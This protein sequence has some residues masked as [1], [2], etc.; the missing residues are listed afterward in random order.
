MRNALLNCTAATVLAAALATSAA[1]E[2]EEASETFVLPN[3]GEIRAFE[4][5]LSPF[6]GEINAFEGQVNPFWGEIRAFWGEINPFWGEIRAFWGEI[7]A[8]DGSL[9]PYWGEIRAFWDEM[10]PEWGTLYAQWGEIRA[11]DDDASDQYQVI[12]RDLETMFEQAEAV[13]GAAVTD[14]SGS[15]F[16]DAFLTTLLAKYDIDLHD[17]SSLGEL[18]DEARS[19]FF[20]DFYDGLMGYSGV[21]RFDHWMGTANWTPALAQSAGLGDGVTVGLL[22]FAYGSELNITT[23]HRHGDRDDFDF[24]HGAAVASLI[25]SPHDGEGLMGVAPDVT[26]NVYNPFD[27][28]L[29]ASWS[30]VA[31]GITKLGQMKSDIINM[32]LGVPGWT[33]HQDWANVLGDSKVAMEAGDAL[34]VIAAGNDGSS[35]QIDVDWS[36]VG[37]AD[38]LLVVG[39]VGPTGEISSFS[40]RPGDACL[41]VNGACDDANRLMNRFLVAPGELVLVSDGEG[42]VT[43]LSG[44]SFAAPLVSG[45]AA[46]VQSRWEWLDAPHTADVLLRSATDLGAPGVDPVYGR[47]MLN[48]EAALSPLDPNALV[49]ASPNGSGSLI[50]ANGQTVSTDSLGNLAMTSGQLRFAAPD[51]HQISAFEVLGDTYRDFVLPLNDVLIDSAASDGATVAGTENYLAERTSE[52][53]QAT[54]GKKK[55][56]K[57][58]F[59]DATEIVTALSAN[60][61]WSLGMTAAPRDPLEQTRDG[62][63]PFQTGLAMTN[64]AAGVEL[65]LGVGEGALALSQQTGFGL[66]SDHRPESGGV[67]PVLG[68]ASG[69]GYVMSGAQLSEATH[70]S[71]GATSTRDEHMYRDPFTGEERPTLTGLS[72]YTATAFLID[73]RHDLSDRVSINAGY[74]LLQEDAGVLG[75]QGST[76]LSL[77]GG[78]RT[79][80]ATFGAEVRAPNRFTASLSATVAQTNATAFDQ[81]NLALAD[82]LMSTAF[83]LTARRDG[84]LGDH[85]ALRAS[86]IQPLHVETGALE[87][88]ETRVVDRETGEM[89]EVTEQW[90]LGGERPLVAEMLY[91]APILDGRADVSLFGRA[92]ISGDEQT[93]DMAGAVAGVRFGMDF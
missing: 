72:D 90:R 1:A 13:F 82:D 6:W 70:V 60:G 2:T 79:D 27:E 43:R 88:T 53:V 64:D 85:D 42:G 4:D 12:A 8:F 68:F 16:Q 46:L 55:K 63:L 25:A 28:S 41:V 17:P 3:W 30:D 39:S 93:A 50:A 59:Q 44:T 84:V 29:T 35:Q 91:A 61:R 7:R 65:R 36:Q 69:G 21:D 31:A 40:N 9:T 56:K 33:L 83:Q 23:K 49:Y 11:F 19:R 20:L 81:S 52:P 10:G 73:A 57:K 34:F 15:S 51:A 38:N 14:A 48:V 80:A 92:N 67:N 18:D 26:M 78:T 22:D 86:I 77:D 58:K 87:Y 62:E 66:F 75:A 32:S 71:F 37:T 89:G 5:D 54:G 76:A 24:N 74:T 47:G 45:A